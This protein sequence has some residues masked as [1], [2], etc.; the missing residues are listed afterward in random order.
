MKRSNGKTFNLRLTFEIGL[1]VRHRTDS[2]NHVHGAKVVIALEKPNLGEQPP[3]P[4]ERSSESTFRNRASSSVAR[5]SVAPLY[6]G[7]RRRTGT[8]RSAKFW[9][10]FLRRCQP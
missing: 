6:A 5:Y 9:K 10:A 7:V 2:P 3:E 1:R 8:F 4:I